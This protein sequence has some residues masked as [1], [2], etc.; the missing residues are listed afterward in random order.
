MANAAVSRAGSRAVRLGPWLCAA[1][2][3]LGAVALIGWIAG[4]PLLS[5]IIPHHPRMMPNTALALVLLGI[6]AALRARE[7][8]GRVAVTVSRALALVALVIAAIAFTEYALDVDLRVHALLFRGVPGRHAGRPPPPTALALM[9]LAAALLVFDRKPHAVARPSDWMVLTAVFTAVGALLGHLFRAHD[10]HARAPLIVGMAFPTAIGVLFIAVGMLLERPYWGVMRVVSSAGPGGVM[11]RRLALPALVMPVL[12]GILVTRLLAVIGIDETE[13]AVASLTA[14][15]TVAGLAQLAV[16]AVPLNRTHEALEQ[17][18]ARARELVDEASDGIFIADVQGRYV[19]VN[20]AGCAM[21]GYDHDELIGKTIM[22]LLRPEDLPRLRRSRERLMTGAV[23]VSE[24]IIL[25]KD[26][27][28]LQVEVSAKFLADGRW[29]GIARDISER[30]RFEADQRFLAEI[31]PALAGTL[32]YDE[33]L[34]K[35]AELPVRELADVCIV[36]ALGEE[37]HAERLK[38]ASRDASASWVCEELMRA[39]GECE[40]ARLFRAAL[41]TRRS[42]LIERVSPETYGEL[43]ET[44]AQGEILR[45]GGMESLI[46]VPLQAHGR[47]LGAIALASCTKARP[48]RARELRLAEE[49]AHRAA[50][51]IENARL[52]RSV[53]RAVEV[54]DEVMGIVAHDL[55]NPLGTVLLH[56]SALARRS[57]GVDAHLRKT[58]ETIERAANRM[59]RLIQDLLDVTRMEA[60]HLPVRREPMPAGQAV[61]LALEEHEAQIAAAG[62][63]AVADVAEGVS[64][65]WA[66]RDRLLQVFENLI[67]NAVKFTARGGRIT[68]GAAPRDQEV[69]FWVA[70]TGRGIESA[71]VPRLFDRF[72]QV[73][74]GGRRGAGLGLPIAKGIVDAHGGRIW[75]ESTPGRGSIFF[76]TVPCTPPVRPSAHMEERSE[77]P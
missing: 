56:A 47:L 22:D 49:L 54:R 61:T 25:H 30:K 59:N 2:A 74:K 52:Y 73:R 1:G 17:V 24:W 27:T 4:V 51:S 29:Q 67:G 50:L 23:E 19:D 28:P 44:P 3:A 26:G 20:A 39:R 31:G 7:E 63:V 40:P 57:E 77:A 69:L 43:A 15:L 13:L 10:F 76:F 41:D 62:L 18:R 16:I 71:D 65:V 6:G 66:D 42:I 11:F 46:V 75:V 70:D 34:T 60:G 37:G 33:I 21:V 36:E 8:A 32:D 35:I 55:R 58:A 72:W 38:M 53:G 64:T 9:L 14:A 5:R 48:Y 68:V 12:F 45:A